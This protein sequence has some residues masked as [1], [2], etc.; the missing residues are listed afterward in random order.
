MQAFFFSDTVNPCR[1]RHETGQNIYVK[2]K[3]SMFFGFASET[4]EI[5]NFFSKL[6]MEFIA[7]S[8]LCVN[9]FYV[10]ALSNGGKFGKRWSDETLISAK[11]LSNEAMKRYAGKEIEVIK[12]STLHRI[13]SLLHCFIASVPQLCIIY[14]GHSDQNKNLRRNDMNRDVLTFWVKMIR[15]VLLWHCSKACQ[16]SHPP[17]AFYLSQW[18][19]DWTSK[20]WTSKDLT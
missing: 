1:N 15:D 17:P 8:L 16:T 3:T 14:R 19:T 9:I 18:F 2:A 13:A 5:M 20:D 10:K 12:H 7:S 4:T 6:P 11:N